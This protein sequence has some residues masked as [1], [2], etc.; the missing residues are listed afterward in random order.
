MLKF[1]TSEGQK[2]RKYMFKII[3]LV[4]VGFILSMSQSSIVLATTCQNPVIAQLEKIDLIQKKRLS[5]WRNYR[6]ELE[7]LESEGHIKLPEIPTYATNNAHMFYLLC[8]TNKQ[9][10]EL[11]AFLK[12]MNIHAVFHYLSLHKSQYYLKDNNEHDLPNSDLFEK[13]LIR[14][15]FYVELSI[16]DQMYITNAIKSFFNLEE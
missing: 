7:S 15:P 4:T 12:N 1:V 14:L 9:R 2:G 5:I 13:R 11:I 3:K 6:V 16:D 10:D 8:K